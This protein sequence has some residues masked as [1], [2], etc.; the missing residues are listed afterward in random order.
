MGRYRKKPV[1]VQAVKLDGSHSSY[2][3]A[4]WLA[5]DHILERT[6]LHGEMWVRT[7][8]GNEVRVDVGKYLVLDGKGFPYPCDAELFE[9]GHEPADV[10][11]WNA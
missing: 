11:G 7:V 9:A 5:G 8:D 6:A 3:E 1:V 10:D 2:E 4:Y